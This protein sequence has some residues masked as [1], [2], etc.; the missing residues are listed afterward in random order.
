MASAATI[1]ALRITLGANT[2]AFETGLKQAASSL[3]GFSSK[4]KVAGA[5][6]AAAMAGA[7]GGVVA[8]IKHSIDEA[9]KMGKMAQS[10]GVPIEELSALKHAA[11][12]SGVSLEQLGVGMGKLS[13]NMMDAAVNGTGPVAQSF[14]ALGLSVKNSD[15]TLKTSSRIMTE[16]AGKF[17]RIKDGAG[18]TAMS[19]VLFGKSGKD[20]IPMLNAGAAGLREMMEEAR[21]LGL[22]IDDKTFKASEA[23]NDNLT[24]MAKI[25]D[26]IFRQVS[27]RL[28]PALQ[29]LSQIMF[30]AAKSTSAMDEIAK[31]LVLTMRGLASAAVIVGGVMK[32]TID[33]YARLVEVGSKLKNLDFSGAHEA[34]TKGAEDY[35]ATMKGSLGIVS[36][37]WDDN[38]AVTG[39]ASNRM[40]DQLAKAAEE[41]AKRAAGIR[42][43]M[44]SA[45]RA[46]HQMMEAGKQITLAVMTPTERLSHELA[47]L[48]ALLDGGA[49]SWE[50]YQRA[51]E[52]AKDKLSG[53]TAIAESVRSSLENAF[54]DVI[55]KAKTFK[56]AIGDLIKQFA[57]LALQQG[58][59]SIFGGGSSGGGGIFGDIAK[60]LFNAA[61]KAATGGSFKVPG[62]SSGVDSKLAMIGVAPGE[63]IDVRKA[64][65]QSGR[66]VV[67][68]FAPTV[69][70]PSG[71]NASE[72]RQ[73]MES[74]RRRFR[75]EVV[76]LVREAAARG[77]L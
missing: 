34:L 23:F 21:A 67:V 64:G 17:E 1:G 48:K 8:G 4:M 15:G 43:A 75:S 69:N 22:V 33:G 42:Q 18:K 31:T 47:R 71:M 3:S 61:P 44:Q 30:D 6:L 56:D 10:V 65:S 58:F 76:P 68:N 26:G 51:V 59:Q 12:L 73:V 45:A 20:L 29:G 11:D 46:Q 7:L 5:A 36:Q 74:E 72:L 16:V 28:V 50:T 66:G 60:S 24:R 70:A 25:K 40:R 14:T 39:A 27:A 55:M 35:T 49:I 41:A 9:D 37:I 52:Q 62:G 63:Q 32:A 54:V 13:K 38:V 19:M 57:K 77:A 2:A 53:F